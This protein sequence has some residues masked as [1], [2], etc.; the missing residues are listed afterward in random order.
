MVEFLL[1][2]GADPLKRIR[3]PVI[4]KAIKDYARD[5]GATFGLIW[6]WIVERKKTLT[7]VDAAGNTALHIAAKKGVVGA[8]NTMLKTCVCKTG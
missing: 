8:L 5:D 4:H 1:R 6:R 3:H 7:H 2:Q